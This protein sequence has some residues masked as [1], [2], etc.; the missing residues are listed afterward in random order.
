MAVVGQWHGD[1]GVEAGEAEARR[2]QAVVQ[3]DLGVVQV[4]GRLSAL[5]WHGGGGLCTVLTPRVVLAP[6]GGIGF[7]Q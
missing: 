2:H 6:V 4:D 1:R 5:V 3:V 7:S